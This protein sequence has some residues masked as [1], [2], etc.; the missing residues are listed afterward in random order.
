MFGAPCF[1]LKM[2]WSF[3]ELLCF[4]EANETS[5]QPAAEEEDDDQGD[6]DVPDLTNFKV[7]ELRQCVL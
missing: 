3:D 2:N 5:A 4:K 7:E 1:V 6:H